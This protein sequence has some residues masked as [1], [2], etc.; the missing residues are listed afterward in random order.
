[1]TRR[2]DRNTVRGDVAAQAQRAPAWPEGF[3]PGNLRRWRTHHHVLTLRCGACHR[4]RALLLAPADAITLDAILER[5]AWYPS[6]GVVRD[7]CV[8]VWVALPAPSTFRGAVA[9]AVRAGLG[10][11]D[12]HTALVVVASPPD[13][14]PPV[15]DGG[16]VPGV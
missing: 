8:C 2:G 14:G 15:R 13:P 9:R 3:D 5:G 12:Q 7:P 10:R 1:V 6:R 11:V 4:P 16:A